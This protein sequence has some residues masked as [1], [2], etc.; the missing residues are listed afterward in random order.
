[1][2]GAG[3]LGDK[4]HCPLDSHSCVSCSHDVI[5]PAIQGS[6][7]VTIN[8]KPAL[9]V[10]DMGIHAPCCGPNTWIVMQGAPTVFINSKAAARM[11]D[12]TL[13][14]GGYGNIV[15]GSG[16]VI[17]GNGQA[18]LFKQA[19]K[20]H[21]P[22]VQNIVASRKQQQQILQQNMEYLHEKG[23]S[24]AY[25]NGQTAETVAR[26]LA[27]AVA[28]SSAVPSIQ[29]QA[30]RNASEAATPLCPICAAAA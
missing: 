10:G 20:E 12:G 9:R 11:T 13:H 4:S 8:S 5:G 26:P 19:A 27:D 28:D 2:P 14:C 17:I 24:G 16:N 7:N 23:A 15:E 1:M 18:R 25:F 3:R 22:F 30:L 29:A 6:P 21:A